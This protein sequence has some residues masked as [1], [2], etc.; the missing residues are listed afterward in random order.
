MKAVD[1]FSLEKHSG[2]YEKW[3]LRSRVLVNGKPTFARIPGYTLLHQFEIDGGY[4]LITDCDCPFEETTSFILLSKSNRVLSFQMLFEPYGSFLLK[5]I[6]WIDG[7]NIKATF[8]ENDTW[9]LTV[10]HRGFPFLR[11]RLWLRRE[12]THL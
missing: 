9:L 10:R 2:P 4:L 11:P 1:I 6:D 5:R 12:S 3:P 8:Y 7:A